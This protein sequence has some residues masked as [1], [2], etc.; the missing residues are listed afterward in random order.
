MVK[1][2]V[3]HSSFAI[4]FSCMTGLAQVMHWILVV[5]CRL[6]TKSLQDEHFFA[7]TLFF[8]LLRSWQRVQTFGE[9][10]SVTIACCGLYLA[11]KPWISAER[12]FYGWSSFHK[13]FVIII[14]VFIA[15]R[16][17]FQIRMLIFFFINLNFWLSVMIT[18]VD[19]I[20]F[21][22]II[23]FASYFFF[24]S[25]R[26]NGNK[27]FISLIA[28]YLFILYY[29]LYKNVKNKPKIFHLFF[30]IVIRAVYFM[31]QTKPSA[32][33]FLITWS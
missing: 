16:L 18:F 8:F 30:Y 21:I 15:L 19:N 13:I 29:Y 12:F 10:V 9:D 26:N 27:A 3:T 25:W 4:L 6:H 33:H 5:E 20:L 17:H 22:I 14:M 23:F 28:K 32:L 2:C 7:V 1:I 24:I 11:K 31:H